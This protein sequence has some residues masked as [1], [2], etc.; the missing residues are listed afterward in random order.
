MSVDS[1]SCS[2]FLHIQLGRARGFR[3]GVL[4]ILTLAAS[5]KRVSG[6]SEAI[7]NVT[8]MVFP[9]LN[10]RFPKE[11]CVN[12]V[13]INF[14]SQ[15]LPNLQNEPKLHSLPSFE[16]KNK[17][18]SSRAARVAWQLSPS[19]LKPFTVQPALDIEASAPACTKTSN[20]KPQTANLQIPT[21][22]RKPA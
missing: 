8:R 1:G 11:G 21:Q 7:R 6:R 5:C 15:D 14:S 20:R 18:Q 19:Q 4:R 9:E 2:N 10:A 12:P 17:I 16:N 3:L 13:L 22:Y